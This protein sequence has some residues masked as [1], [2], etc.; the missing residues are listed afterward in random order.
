MQELYGQCHGASVMLHGGAG[1]PD[2]KTSDTVKIATVALRA[3][4]RAALTNLKAG[5]HPLDVVVDCLKAMELDEQFN[6]GRGSALQADGQARLT[7]ALMD[8]SRSSFSAVIS[9]SYLV[10][11]SV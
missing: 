1:A 3:I 5:K 11:P 9:A 10:H 4:G 2:P 8:G 6:A 7:A